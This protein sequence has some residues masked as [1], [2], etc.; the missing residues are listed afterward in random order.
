MTAAQQLAQLRAWQENLIE[1]FAHANPQVPIQGVAHENVI[2]PG[3]PGNARG[4]RR[5]TLVC[6]VTL[7]ALGGALAWLGNGLPDVGDALARSGAMFDR[8]GAQ[9]SALGPDAGWQGT[10]AAAYVAQNQAQSQHAGLMADLDRLAAELVSSQAHGVETARDVV[11]LEILVVMIL[12][13]ACVVFELEGPAGQLLSF[14]IA[15]PICGAALAVAAGFL[16]DLAVRTSGKASSLEAVTQRLT[17]MVAALPRWCD[18]IPGAPEVALPQ[19]HCP[20]GFDVA[21]ETARSPHTPDPRAALADLPGSPEFN[22]PSVAAPGFPDFGAPHLPIPQLAGMPALPDLS[23]VLANLPTLRQ[24]SSLTGPTSAISQLA[25]TATQHAQ[26]ISS[27]AQQGAQQ[28]ATL[29][30]R[31]TTGHDDDTPDTE[32]ATADTEGAT[33]D[34]TVGER[35]PIDAETRPNDQQR[36]LVV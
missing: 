9:I 2:E 19:P 4:F 18:I 15:I 34:T 6:G 31:L 12:F 26:M 16:I 22:A 24:L 21:D 25:N 1:Q 8:A 17:A 33:A 14:K 36:G 3:A 29:A 20:A 30:D 35:A 32:G 13:G 23:G 28:H 5:G 10:A 11:I 7:G 27:L